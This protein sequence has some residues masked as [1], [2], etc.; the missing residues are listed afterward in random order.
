MSLSAPLIAAIAGAV[1][2]SGALNGVVGFGFALV[3]TMVVAT[4]VS[5]ATA[6]VLLIIPIFAVNLSLVG[7][8]DSSSL[9]NCTRRFWPYIGTALVGTVFGMAALNVIPDKPLRLGL[10]VITLL[11]VVTRQSVV[12]IPGRQTGA[13][14]CFVE[15]PIQMAGLGVVSGVLF[16]ATNVGVQMVAY[17]KSCDLDHSVFVGVVALTFLGINGSRVIVAA[18]LDLYSSG[19]IALL[20]VVLAVPAIVGAMAGKRLRPMFSEHRMRQLVLLLLSVI[21]G[22][23]LLAGSGM[24]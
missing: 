21:G 11:F 7:E 5:P 6:V 12:S 19:T 9:R 18:G 3:G 15:A 2:F 16:G 4:I 1:L 13:N 22:R 24:V 10:G 17:L 14:T 23:L 8:L 20:S